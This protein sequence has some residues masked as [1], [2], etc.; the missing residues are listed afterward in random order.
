MTRITINTLKALCEHLNTITNS[1]LQPYTR[2]AEGFNANI[3][4]FHISQAYGGF[5]LQRM[6]N[7]G[8]GVTCPLSQG[9]IPA[10]ELYNQ[11]QSFIRGLEYED[12]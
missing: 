10:R 3:G 2:S 4:N 11:M 9:H 6:V 1:P 8:G 5:C 7:D 12:K